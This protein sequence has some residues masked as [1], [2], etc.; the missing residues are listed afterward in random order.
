M[1]VV[2][3]IGANS[4]IAYELALN[5][6][7]AFQPTLF[8]LASKN[9]DE[10]Q[11]TAN[12]IAIRTQVTTEAIMLDIEDITQCKIFYEQLSI[13][14]DVVAYCAGYLGDQNQAMQNNEEA[15]KILSVNYTGAMLLLNTVALDMAAKKHGLIIGLSSVAGLRGRKKNYFYGA[16]KAAFTTY[17]SGLR[18]RLATDQVQVITVL[19]GFVD[20]KMVRHLNLPKALTATPNEVARAIIHAI[21]QSQNII[22]VKKSWRFIMWVIENIPEKIFKRLNL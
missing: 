10:L 9:L 17:L 1:R 18:N 14:P 7:E 3:M 11:Q 4:D 2:L 12:D 6:A 22:Y 19:L 5:I 20:T 8:L 21:N 15:L 16:A 13:K